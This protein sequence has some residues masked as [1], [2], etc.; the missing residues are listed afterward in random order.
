[1]PDFF[2]V[3]RTQRACRRFSSDPVSDETV[4]T[5][6]SAATFAPSAENH[7]PW[8]F[9]VVRDDERRRQLAEMS[10]KVWNNWARNYVIDTSDRHI[11]TDIDQAVS[12]GYAS[13]PVSI[14][15]CGDSEIGMAE[16]MPESIFPATQNLL[17]AAN[18][19]GLGSALITL[20]LHA[21]DELGKLLEL[22]AHVR[23]MAVIPIGHPARPLGP[24]KRHHFTARTHRERYGTAW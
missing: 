24:P 16:A 14:V 5:I 1:M 12:G 7:Q 13:A 20:P 17:L 15:V 4:E 19:L 8:V 10:A 23:A 3:V 18:A 9:I 22:P 21:G 6:L 2:D 11:L